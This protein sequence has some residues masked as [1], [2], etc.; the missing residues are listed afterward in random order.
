MNSRSDIKPFMRIHSIRITMYMGLECAIAYCLVTI[1][2][3]FPMGY[4]AWDI[5]RM[6][7][8]HTHSL[9]VQNS[10]ISGYEATRRKRAFPWMAHGV[11]GGN[12]TSFCAPSC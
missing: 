12:E 6:S 8:G 10:K 2:M 3:V 9:V 11:L 1:V 5:K 4:Y 7:L